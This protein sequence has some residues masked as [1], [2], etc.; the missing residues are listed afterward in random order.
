MA[1][2]P[3]LHNLHIGSRGARTGV[4]L[5]LRAASD[6]ADS[7]GKGVGDFSTTKDVSDK[8]GGL[9]KDLQEEFKETHKVSEKCKS[10]PYP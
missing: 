3:P 7:S 8:L 9:L 10:D 1:A 2:L 4:T 5:E 6:E